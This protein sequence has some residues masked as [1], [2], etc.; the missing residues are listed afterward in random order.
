[1]AIL[2]AA[3]P[4]LPYPDVCKNITQL[5]DSSHIY[6]SIPDGAE[7]GHSLLSFTRDRHGLLKSLSS[8]KS[9]TYVSSSYQRACECRVVPRA[10]ARYSVCTGFNFR[11][12]ITSNFPLLL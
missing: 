12:A 5:H 4:R 3:L 1:M 11:D 2:C 10:A 6:I 7:D 9:D 8:I